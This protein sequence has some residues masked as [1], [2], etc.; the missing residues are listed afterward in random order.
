MMKNLERKIKDFTI[1]YED[2]RRRDIA[3]LR[4]E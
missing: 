4:N 2:R 3:D 1:E